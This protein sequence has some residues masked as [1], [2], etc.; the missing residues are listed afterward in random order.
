[1]NDELLS[2]DLKSYDQVEQDVI[3]KI[4]A[5]EQKNTQAMLGGGPDAAAILIGGVG[6][7]DGLFGATIF[8]P[9]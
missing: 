5:E 7:P 1:M 9:Q 4:V 6:A 2:Q 8:Q 3:M